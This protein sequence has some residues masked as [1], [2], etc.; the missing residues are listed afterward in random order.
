[1]LIEFLFEAGG[2]TR[3]SAHEIK[4]RPTDLV[5]T[6]DQHFIQPRRAEQESALHAHTIGCHPAYGERGLIATFAESDHG[7]LEFLNA[8]TITFFDLHMHIDGS[9]RGAI[10]GYF[11]FSWPQRPLSGLPF[12]ILP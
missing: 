9:R 5:V 10:Q 7:A 12:L 2:L 6:F 11:R 8:L 4:L 1:M 3:A